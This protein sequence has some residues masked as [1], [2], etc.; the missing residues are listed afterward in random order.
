MPSCIRRNYAYQA[1]LELPLGRWRKLYLMTL[2]EKQ[3]CVCNVKVVA[4]DG[5]LDKRGQRVRS[6][7]IL[8]RDIQKL[9]LL[10]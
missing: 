10:L 1:F 6:K 8:E 9:I 2:Q 3:K 5:N 7:S 4:D